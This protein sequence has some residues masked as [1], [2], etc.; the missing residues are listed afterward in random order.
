VSLLKNKRCF[1]KPILERISSQRAMLLIS[2]G[3]YQNVM[4]RTD[5]SNDELRGLLIHIKREYLKRRT[6]ISYL[7][8]ILKKKRVKTPKFPL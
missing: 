3:I 7:M 4:F 6:L 8:F 5:W 2:L 1:A